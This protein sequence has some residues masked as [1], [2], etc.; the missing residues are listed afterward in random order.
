[1]R[2]TVCRC[3]APRPDEYFAANPRLWWSRIW[4]RVA[5]GRTVDPERLI[6]ELRRLIA[7]GEPV[8]VALRRLQSEADVGYFLLAPAVMTV[9]GVEPREARRLVVQAV[10]SSPVAEEAPTVS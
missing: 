2:L 10:G 3:S 5:G 8:A 7:S 4:R 6:A 1:M 9:L